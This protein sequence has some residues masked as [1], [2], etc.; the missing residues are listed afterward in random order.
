MGSRS[1]MS[2]LLPQLIL[3]AVGGSIAPPLL[4]LTILFLGSQRSLSNATALVVGYFAVCAAVG[5]AG[6]ILFGG[7]VGAGSTTSTIGR[8]ISATVG[9]LLIVLGLRSLLNTPDPDAPPPRWMESVSSMTPAKAFGIGMVLFP[10]QIKNLA[11]FV[12]CI[13]LIATTSFSTQGSIVA[14]VLVLLIFTIPVL[15]LI[16]LYTAVP[17]RASYMLV[18]LRAWMEKHNRTITVVLC[19]VFGVFF[20]VRGFSG[21]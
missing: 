16:G 17:Q 21:L 6:L 15:V 9:G 11:I 13:N 3:L 5:I 1:F 20:L 12:A 8:V 2:D 18:S 19:F 14:L 4:L 10:I 7:A